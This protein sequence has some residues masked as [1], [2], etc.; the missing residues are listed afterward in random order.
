MFNKILSKD[1]FRQLMNGRIINKSVL[2]NSGEFIENK[3]F[4][5]IMQN[6]D[7]YRNQYRMS[8]YDFVENPEFIYIREQAT[9]KEELKTDITIKACVLLLLL[10]KYLTEHNFRISK[11][12]DPTGGVTESDFEIIQQ[13]PDTEEILEKA[14]MKRDI[15][16]S[17]KSVLVDRHILL[18]KP[19]SCSYILSEAGKAFFDEIVESYQS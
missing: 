16:S 8:G 5:E 15:Q 1:I 3:L 4:T 17:I 11:L 2:S 6:I 13:M 14:G 19:S 18:Q 12:T 7:D 10:G 9:R